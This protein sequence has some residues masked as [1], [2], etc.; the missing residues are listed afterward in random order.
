MLKALR[1]ITFQR[2]FLCMLML[3]GLWNT[4]AAEAQPKPEGAK[5]WNILWI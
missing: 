5:R 4:L 3:A 2:I 1:F